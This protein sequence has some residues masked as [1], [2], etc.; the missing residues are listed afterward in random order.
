MIALVRIW[1]WGEDEKDAFLVLFLLKTNFLIGFCVERNSYI[2][3]WWAATSHVSVATTSPH[4]V[5]SWQIWL[6]TRETVE[7][8]WCYWCAPA[9]EMS[10]RGRNTRT[11]TEFS[12]H[13]PFSLTKGE[14][15]A[16]V[17]EKSSIS[18][19]NNIFQHFLVHPEGKLFFCRKGIFVEY[20]ANPHHHYHRYLITI[21]VLNQR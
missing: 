19:C 7:A 10:Q 9:M 21:N 14:G 17:K 11:I 8:G 20:C 16:P 12:K 5:E 2:L 3:V 15:A 4:Q 18:R 13:E 6:L 1:Y